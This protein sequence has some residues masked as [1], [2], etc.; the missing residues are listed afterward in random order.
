MTKSQLQESLESL[1][2]LGKLDVASLLSALQKTIEFE[3]ELQNQ[4]GKIITIS[5]DMMSSDADKVRQK[6][7]RSNSKVMRGKDA[8]SMPALSPSILC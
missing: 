2:S 1:H 8:S 6:Y 7:G 5:D 3:N 4:Y